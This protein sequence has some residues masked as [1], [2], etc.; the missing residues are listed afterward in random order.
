MGTALLAVA[1]PTPLSL[2]LPALAWVTLAGAVV[3][4]AIA[5]RVR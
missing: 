3:A 2:G 5:A 1:A 4:F